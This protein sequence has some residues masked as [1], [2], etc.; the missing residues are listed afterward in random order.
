MFNNVVNERP[1]RDVKT[2]LEVLP[3]D[4]VTLGDVFKGLR[5]STVTA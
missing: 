2:L 1:E 5:E 4:H 3:N